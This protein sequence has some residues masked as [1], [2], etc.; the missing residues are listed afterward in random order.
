MSALQELLE[1]YRKTAKNERDKGDKFERL[2]K[3]FLEN[4]TRFSDRFSDVW[5]WNKFPGNEGK[6]D[7]GIDLVAKEKYSDGYC[8]IQCK[9]YGD[10]TTVDKSSLTTIQLLSMVISRL[11]LPCS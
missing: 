4:D 3:F 10:K 1:H 8:A 5:I 11:P 2:T 7:T 9:F 6:V